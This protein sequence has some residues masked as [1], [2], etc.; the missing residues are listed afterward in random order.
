MFN[1]CHQIPVVFGPWLET[2][3]NL[4]FLKVETLNCVRGRSFEIAK[5]SVRYQSQIRAK[6]N[7]SL[8]PADPINPGKIGCGPQQATTRTRARDQDDGS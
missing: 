6:M 2:V 5:R 1:K 7:T 3:K 4:L 8:D